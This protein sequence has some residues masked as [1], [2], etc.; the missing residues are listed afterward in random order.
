MFLIF[1]RNNVFLFSVNM[2]VKHWYLFWLESI[3]RLLNKLLTQGDHYINPKF[4]FL[5]YF[6][7]YL[8]IDISRHMEWLQ[9]VKQSHSSV[10]ETSLM[11]A[12][13]INKQGVYCIGCLDENVSSSMLMEQ[14][15]LANV[16]QLKVPK[17]KNGNSKDYTLDDLKDLQSKLM[18][19][20]GKASQGKEDVDRFVDVSL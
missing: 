5:L 11:E 7:L 20:A 17:G 14:L 4:F 9:S 12:Q 18:L 6:F 19:I 2:L 8:Q 15:T 16:I 1:Q 3:V 13:T 10:D